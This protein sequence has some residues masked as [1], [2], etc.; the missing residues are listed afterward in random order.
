MKILIVDD[1]ALICESMASIL[2]TFLKVKTTEIVA[3]GEAA[4]E[5]IKAQHYD[6]VILDINLPGMNGI[7][8]LEQIKK[9]DKTTKVVIYTNYPLPAY[10]AQCIKLGADHF[11]DKVTE[12]KKVLHVVESM[13][14]L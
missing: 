6:L 9:I 12:S 13:L 8:V 14:P 4:I 3:N 10:K 11:L 7:K 1:S 5:L 2:S